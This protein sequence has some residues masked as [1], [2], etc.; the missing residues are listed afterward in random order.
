[1]LG[2]GGG[3]SSQI[4]GPYWRKAT[5]RGGGCVPSCAE[6][7]AKKYLDEVCT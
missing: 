1:M 5:S 6:R 2:G 3:G 4:K 7:E